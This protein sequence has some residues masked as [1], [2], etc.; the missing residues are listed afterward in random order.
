VRGLPAARIALV[1]FV[2]ALAA[3]GTVEVSNTTTSAASSTTVIDSPTTTAEPTTSTTAAVTTTTMAG[4][5]AAPAF[6]VPYEFIAT[7]VRLAKNSGIADGWIDYRSGTNQF[8]LFT[9]GGP[10]SVEA[11]L[12]FLTTDERMIT[13]EPQPSEIGGQP[14]TTVDV[15]LA[16]PSFTMF[17]YAPAPGENASWGIVEG[18]ANR[19]HL[20]G[21]EDVTVAI[22]IEAPEDE[23]EE[24]ASAVDASLTTLEWNPPA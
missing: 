6:A 15:R 21:F 2:L 16:G 13:T 1:V 14:A 7:E 11:W 17:T 23:F 12:E 8:V 3:C 18:S 5:V 24:F 20:V 4:L 10:G 9:I 22:L 19:I